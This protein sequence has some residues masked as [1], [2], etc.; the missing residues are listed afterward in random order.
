MI[1]F[2]RIPEEK[3]KTLKRDISLKEQIEKFTDAR[4]SL[5][6][7]VLIECEDPLIVL[8]IKEV[9]KAFGRGFEFK[10][11][12]NLLDE[13]YSLETIKIKEYTGKSR[14]RVLIMKGR[15][16]GTK[17][18]TK[19]LIEKYTDTKLAIYGKT[20]SIIGKW[21]DVVIAKKAVEMILSGSLHGTVYR[22]L[23]EQKN[24]K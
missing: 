12:M 11:A 22:F 23:E 16:I 13:E 17:G 20:I 10:N 5:N 21:S 4:I 6:D 8:R 15:L 1:E 9:M 7:E 3:L 19:N 18:K 2:V 24:F 14:D